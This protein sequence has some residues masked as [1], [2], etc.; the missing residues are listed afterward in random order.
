MKKQLLVFLLLTSFLFSG[1]SHGGAH[2]EPINP[3][4]DVPVEPETPDNPDDP[5]QPEEPDEEDTSKI[6]HITLNKQELILTIGHY[7]YLSVNFFPDDETTQDIH[8]GTWSIADSSIA[9]ISIYGKVTAV[10][11]G[12]TVA[13]FTTVEGSRRAN[14]TVYVFESEQAIQKEYVKV[15]DA[16]SIKDGDQIIFASPELKVAASINRLSGYL[17][18]TNATFSTD[19]NKLLTF[20]DDAGQ[21]YVGEGKNG[22]LTLENQENEYLCGKTNDYRN[23]LTFVKSKGS[24]NWIFEIPE[25]YSNI[26]CVNNDLADDLWL[27][28]NR[29]N[30]S[31]IRFN[32]Y[33]SNPTALMI[34]PTIY[35]LEITNL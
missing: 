16:D 2:S 29:I 24:I 10:K 12:K 25:G 6:D 31:D 34:M 33:D 17:K 20:G 5:V 4:P 14:C 22:G 35:R 11:K 30:D 13:S 18:P 9:T 19:G 1:C 28:F 15:T 3:E 7:E 32:L 23:S 26:Y 8:D 21:Y 27:M